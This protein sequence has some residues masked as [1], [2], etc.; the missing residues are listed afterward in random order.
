MIYK[1][2]F[3]IFLILFPLN[4]FALIEVDITR[5]NLSPLPVAVSSLSS[6]DEDKE[7]L[8]KRLKIE[9]LGLEISKVVEN[10]SESI[11]VEAADQEDILDQLVKSLKPY[12]ISEI[13]RT[14]KMSMR[15]G[16]THNVTSDKNKIKSEEDKWQP[17]KIN[18]YHN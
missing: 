9:D 15:K 10:N 11:I 18:S 3:T 14:G 5:G 6:S 7:A 2:L 13:M 1:K 4:S 8:K 17:E 12:N 16:K